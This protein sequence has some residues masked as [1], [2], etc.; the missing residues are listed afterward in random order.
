MIKVDG[1]QITLPAGDTLRIDVGIR[2]KVE[3]K[4]V[5]YELSEGDR[6]QFVLKEDVT[7]DLPIL[8]KSIPIDTKILELSSQ[9]TSSLEPRRKQPY[10]FDIKLIAADGT[11]DTFIKGKLYIID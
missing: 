4:Y 5:D 8:T 2:V 10:A 3:G 7:D 1:Y 11:V 9:E 6:L